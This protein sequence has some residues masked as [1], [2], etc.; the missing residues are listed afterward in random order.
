MVG[1]AP[2]S[3]RGHSLAERRRDNEPRNRRMTD[4]IAQPNINQR[5]AGS[6]R[7]HRHVAFLPLSD[8]VDPRYLEPVDWA[9]EVSLSERHATMT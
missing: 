7:Q 5:R 9:D 4:V 8:A 3:N 2:L 1:A 6:P